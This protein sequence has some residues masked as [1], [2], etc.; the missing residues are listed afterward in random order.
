MSTRNI[1]PRA[2]EEGNLGTA[3]KKWL[4]G[5]FKDLFVS[6]SITDGTNSATVEQLVAGASVFGQN[7]DHAESDGESSTTST[8]F[9]NKLNLTTDTLPVGKYRIGWNYEWNLNSLSDDF[10]AR[11]Q[12]NNTTDIME[13]V[14]EPKDSGSDQWS[15]KG[16]F[17]VYDLT[18]EGVLSIDLDY[19]SP[20]AD[21]A[22]IRRARLEIW[23]VE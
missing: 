7:A 14:Q 23:R 22:K 8:S 19:R 16:G 3:I 4:K 13:H 9:Q 1:V 2:N 18:S 5:W 10:E 20:S 17:G 21:T 15:N 12:V 6:G 11:V